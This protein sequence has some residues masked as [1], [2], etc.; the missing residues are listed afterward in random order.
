MIITQTR[1]VCLSAHMYFIFWSLAETEFSSHVSDSASMRAI[2]AV[3]SR[4]SGIS[5]TVPVPELGSILPV[6]YFYSSQEY[7][8]NLLEM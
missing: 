6:F 4:P 3:C 7:D 1:V 5:L 8:Q 2:A